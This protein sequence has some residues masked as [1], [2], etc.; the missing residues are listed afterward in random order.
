M[1]TDEELNKKIELSLER[2]EHLKKAYGISKA[3]KV[4]KE[5]F[6]AIAEIVENLGGSDLLSDEMFNRWGDLA[7][8][9]QQLTP[10]RKKKAR[11]AK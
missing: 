11:K 8:W 2:L 10:V 1:S 5:E 4:I 6:D 3:R 9:D 7:N